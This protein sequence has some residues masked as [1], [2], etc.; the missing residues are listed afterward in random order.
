MADDGSVP[1]M[2]PRGSVL[3][4]TFSHFFFCHIFVNFGEPPFWVALSPSFQKLSSETCKLVY[5]VLVLP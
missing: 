2:T 3:F 5:T 4:T 1:H